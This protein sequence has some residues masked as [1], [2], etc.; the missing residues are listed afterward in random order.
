MSPRPLD[1][2]CKGANTNFKLNVDPFH[3][4]GLNHIESSR[5]RDSQTDSCTVSINNIDSPINPS[6]KNNDYKDK[7]KFSI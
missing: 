7:S 2:Y 4:M 3:E 5:E 6:R 1:K